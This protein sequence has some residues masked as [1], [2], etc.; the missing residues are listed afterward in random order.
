MDNKQSINLVSNKISLDLTSVIKAILKIEEDTPD[1]FDIRMNKDNFDIRRNKDWLNFYITLESEYTEVNRIPLS[2]KE[3]WSE[4]F[5]YGVLGYNRIYRVVNE[6]THESTC[7]MVKEWSDT[8]ENK[9]KS[10]YR[11]MDGSEY[12]K[13]TTITK[14]RESFLR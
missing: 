5:M 11:F 7:F 1:H 10:V 4:F 9:I 6:L 12:T 2:L 14:A 3:V 13:L 8:K